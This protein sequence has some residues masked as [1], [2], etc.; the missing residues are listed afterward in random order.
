[1]DLS[2]VPPYNQ[3]FCRDRDGR[4]FVNYLCPIT[5]FEYDHRIYFEELARHRASIEAKLSE[6]ATN[7]RVLPKYLW[8]ASYHNWFCDVLAPHDDAARSH[9]IEVPTLVP[10][11]TEAR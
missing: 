2:H 7:A 9:K 3:P 11:S 5:E 4:L 8:S 6:F 10:F 1:M